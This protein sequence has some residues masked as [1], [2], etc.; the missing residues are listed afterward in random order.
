MF[1]TLFC[2]NV[3][4]K[5]IQLIRERV[6]EKDPDQRLSTTSSSIFNKEAPQPNYLCSNNFRA[7]P[8]GSGSRDGLPIIFSHIWGYSY[9]I[10]SINALNARGPLRSTAS[11]KSPCVK[12]SVTCQMKA[13]LGQTENFPQMFHTRI[14]NGIPISAKIASNIVHCRTMLNALYFLNF[15]QKQLNYCTKWWQQSF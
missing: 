1:W 6:F 5:K 8:S 4:C 2:W 12:N 9:S 14:H 7:L 11:I 15:S 3:D 13:L 10:N